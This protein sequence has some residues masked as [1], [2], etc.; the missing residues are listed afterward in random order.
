MTNIH[1]SDINEGS[2]VLNPNSID[3][4]KKNIIRY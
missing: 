2:M 3:K 1:L 4:R